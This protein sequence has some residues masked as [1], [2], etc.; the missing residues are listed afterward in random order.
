MQ[1]WPIL[2][3][4]L[5]AAD[6]GSAQAQSPS[7]ADSGRGD[8]ASGE[9]LAKRWCAACHLVSRNQTSGASDAPTFASLGQNPQV[10]PQWLALALLGPHTPMPDMSLSRR[11]VADL[12]AYIKSQGQ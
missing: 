4:V 5:L 10:G 11:E 12:A 6:A 3:A 1:P 7:Q 2:L 8:A 9:V